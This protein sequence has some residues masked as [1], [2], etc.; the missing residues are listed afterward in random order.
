[1]VSMIK[2][3]EEERRAMMKAIVSRRI[4]ELEEKITEIKKTQRGWSKKS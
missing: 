1:M 3:T 2:L 4:Q